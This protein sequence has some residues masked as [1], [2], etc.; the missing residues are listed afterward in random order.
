MKRYGKIDLIQHEIV[1]GLRT[2]GCSVQLLSSVGGGC[3]DILVGVAGAKG[4]RRNI[5][6]EIKSKGGKVSA[7]QTLWMDQWRGQVSVVYSLDQALEI[8]SKAKKKV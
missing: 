2:I 3:P 4:G 8:I 5:L 7:V 6:M 1:Q